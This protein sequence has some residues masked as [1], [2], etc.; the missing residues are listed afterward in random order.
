[1]CNLPTIRGTNREFCFCTAELGSLAL[2][3]TV[4]VYR[5][6]I[7]YEQFQQQAR[8]IV[9]RKPF[10]YAAAASCGCC[11]MQFIVKPSQ[12]SLVIWLIK[13]PNF[14]NCLATISKHREAA[15]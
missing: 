14:L 12:S 8:S 15:S 2:N 13:Q 4:V 7:V 9:E 5:S 6:N 11:I 1:M 10:V 3:E